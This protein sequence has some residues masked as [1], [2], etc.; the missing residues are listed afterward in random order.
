MSKILVVIVTFN[1][2]KHIQ[3]CLESFDDSY[4]QLEITIVDSGSTDTTYLDNLISKQKINIIKK[5]NIGFVAANNIALKNIESFDWVLFLN[6]DARIESKIFDKLLEIVAKEK[7]SK[8]GVFTVPLIRFDINSQKSVGLYDSL[9]ISCSALGRWYDLGSNQPLIDDSTGMQE[10]DAVCGAFMCIRASVLLA[11]KD[12]YG[13]VGFESSFFMYKEDIELSLRIKKAG[14]KNYICKDF[15]A[16]HCRGWNNNRKKVP[17]WA[18]TH[19]AKN[20]L[21]LAKKYKKRALIYA[22]LKYLYVKFVEK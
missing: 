13:N 7:Y 12:S 22:Y 17:L 9:G 5:N 20:D 16:Y 3:W 14:W 15:F 10:V 1:S 18:K 19:S 4:N 21:Y 8:G 2:E 11:C 6:P